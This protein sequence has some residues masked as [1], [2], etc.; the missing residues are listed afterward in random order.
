MGTNDKNNTEKQLDT[1]TLR[2][3]RIF[4]EKQADVSKGAQ[5][6]T[7]SAP[8]Q[9]ERELDDVMRNATEGEGEG[10][11]DRATDPSGKKLVN[12]L[13]DQEDRKSPAPR[14]SSPSRTQ[15]HRPDQESSRASIKGSKELSQKSAM[16][17]DGKAKH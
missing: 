6:M 15:G 17:T 1:E 14:P 16:G 10:G 13:L 11:A 2:Q 7:G 8:Q 5:Q 3:Q 4:E 12:P 9:G